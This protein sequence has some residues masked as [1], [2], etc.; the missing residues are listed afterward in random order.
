MKRFVILFIAVSL[1]GLLFNW[2]SNLF[3]YVVVMSIFICV[4]AFTWFAMLW[5]YKREDKQINAALDSIRDEE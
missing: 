4:Y 1:M 3:G 5:T 2:Y